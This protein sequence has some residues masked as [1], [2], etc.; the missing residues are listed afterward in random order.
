MSM[1]SNFLKAFDPKNKSHVDWLAR[2][3]DLAENMGD[4]AK[5]MNMLSDINTNPLGITLTKMEALD[6]PHVHFVLCAAY[7]KAVLRGL[8]HVPTP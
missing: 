1:T 6:W 8:A 7:A 5:S 2:M 3:M 4:P